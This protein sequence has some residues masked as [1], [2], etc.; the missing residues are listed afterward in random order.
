MITFYYADNIIWN[1]PSTYI[2][3]NTSKLKH[4]AKTNCT[5]NSILFH[6]VLKKVKKSYAE[7]FQTL[8]EFVHI[9]SA[10]IQTWA[11]IMW[12]RTLDSTRDLSELLYY[13]ICKKL[14]S[15][16]FFVN[17]RNTNWIESSLL[18]SKNQK[19][20]LLLYRE[21]YASMRVDVIL[22]FWKSD[23]LWFHMRICDTHYWH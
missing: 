9:I 23:L 17:F 14:C 19:K 16:F 8:Y 6:R 18:K 12:K 11:E 5:S 4:L 1:F 3:R 21:M 22:N 20:I 13:K 2:S 15:I 10:K 7:N